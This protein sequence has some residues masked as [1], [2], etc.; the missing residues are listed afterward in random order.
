MG[1]FKPKEE[2]P[3]QIKGLV[4]FD[5]SL[6]RTLHKLGEGKWKRILSYF[7]C[8]GGFGVVRAAKI[9]T[10]TP[11]KPTRFLGIPGK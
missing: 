2:A 10:E 8:L 6:C 9:L 7:L 3:V 5:Y 4:R 1:L 11:N